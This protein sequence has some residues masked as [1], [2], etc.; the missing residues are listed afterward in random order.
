MD[1]HHGNGTQSI[2]YERPEVLLV[3]LHGDPHTEYPFYL[4]MPTDPAQGLARGDPIS[5]FTLQAVDF[6]RLGARLKRLGCSA[7]FVL[8]GAYAV[9][10]L[11]SNAANVAD[12]FEQG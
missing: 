6:P 4:G 1:C 5:T 12:A 11:G 7:I 3:S 8:E 2:F 10:E 9:S